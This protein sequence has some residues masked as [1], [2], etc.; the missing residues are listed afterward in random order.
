M[1]SGA[2]GGNPALYRGSFYYLLPFLPAE[3][4]PTSVNTGQSEVHARWFPL[5]DTELRAPY[6]D[7]RR[8]RSFITGRGVYR[9]IGGGGASEV[10]P[11]QEKGVGGKSFSPK[12]VG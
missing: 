1:A 2:L 4:T 10:L 3:P 12:V 9:M 6:G 11:L 8:D 7:Q 5:V